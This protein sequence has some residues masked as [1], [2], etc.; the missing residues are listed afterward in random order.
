M[1][2]IT[3]LRFKKDTSWEGENELSEYYT[4][5][6]KR[7]DLLK[8]LGAPDGKGGYIFDS[9]K[10]EEHQEKYRKLSAEYGDAR[11]DYDDWVKE[12]EKKGLKLKDYENKDYK[13]FN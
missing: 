4:D 5:A 13:R 9:A 6:D 12:Q 8:F 10:W 3:P 1:A 7:A 11:K 2:E